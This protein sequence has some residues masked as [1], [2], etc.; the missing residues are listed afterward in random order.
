MLIRMSFLGKW[1]WNCGL[2]FELRYVVNVNLKFSSNGG[3]RP[4]CGGSLI[5]SRSVLTA[6]HC[7]QDV[8]NFKVVVGEHDVTV[9]DGEI[10]VTPQE[11]IDHPEYNRDTSD[12]DFAIITLA[13]PV[14]FSSAVGTICLPS[15]S[16][17]CENLLATITGWGTT[18]YQGTQPNILKKVIQQEYCRM[19]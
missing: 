4:F 5:S 11:W 10:S 15:A 7:K 3:S 18:S 8:S 13:S 1:P 9:A 12:N 16:E 14:T 6:A 2:N 19:S 17:S